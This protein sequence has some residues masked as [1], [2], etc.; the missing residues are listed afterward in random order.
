MLTDGKGNCNR[1]AAIQSQVTICEKNPD[2]TEDCTGTAIMTA[3][4]G[5]HNNNNNND[6]TVFL[7]KIRNYSAPFT[8]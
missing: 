8:E 1:R 7:L 5:Q 2:G 6:N 4:E 3:N